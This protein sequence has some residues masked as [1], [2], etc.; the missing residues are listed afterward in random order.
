MS[1]FYDRRNF[2]DYETIVS[3]I[4]TDIKSVIT[5]KV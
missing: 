2:W 1:H 4:K 5:N 3:F